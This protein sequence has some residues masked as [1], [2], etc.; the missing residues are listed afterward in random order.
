[1]DESFSKIVDIY[2]FQN[3]V[4]VYL[5]I[6]IHI[7]FIHTRNFHPAIF[8]CQSLTCRFWKSC[9]TYFSLFGQ[10]ELQHA[11]YK[12]GNA[13]STKPPFPSKRDNRKAAEKFSSWKFSWLVGDGRNT[14][15]IH[16][17]VYFMYDDINLH[18]DHDV[19]LPKNAFPTKSH[20]HDRFFEQTLRISDWT[21]RKRGF[22]LCF[23]QG[24]SWISKPYHINPSFLGGLCHGWFL[25]WTHCCWFQPITKPMDFPSG[26]PW[27]DERVR[28]FRRRPGRIDPWN[29]GTCWRNIFQ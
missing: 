22:W 11:L 7:F 12:E 19:S 8:V 5:N 14:V 6:Y 29:A 1:M 25:G 10:F 20:P 17:Y 3:K 23:L 18:R 2:L 27:Q 26:F 16:T 9:P 28:E 4:C 15:D 24:F 21:V 13:F